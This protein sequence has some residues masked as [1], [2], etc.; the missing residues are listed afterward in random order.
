M[1]PITLTASSI[2]ATTATLTLAEY[3]GTWWLKRTTPASTN[4]KSMG[5]A[6]ATGATEDLTS[7]TPGASHTYKAYSDSACTNEI[8]AGSFTTPVTVSSID[9]TFLTSSTIGVGDTGGTNFMVGQAF[10]TGSNAGGYTLSSVKAPFATGT[11]SPGNVVVKLHA[12]STGNPSDPGA[13]LS[14]LSGT[15]STPFD[16]GSYLFTC[17]TNCVLAASTTYFVSIEAPDAPND[18]RYFWQTTSLDS[19]VKAPATNGWSIADN[20]KLGVKASDTWLDINL[21][22][23]QMI[24]TAVPR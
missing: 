14:T 9:T 7:L 10:T 11:G 23:A 5:T 8:V 18:A 21:Y 1:D 2:T 19:E 20:G 12:A 4:C 6:A 22:A 15:D 16:E 3:T 13:E 17:T 24:L